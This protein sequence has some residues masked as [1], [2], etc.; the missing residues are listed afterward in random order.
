MGQS[1]PLFVYFRSFLITISIQ[2]EKSI[3]GVLGIQT[4]GRKMVGADETTE[5]W[6]P[7]TLCICW[8]NNIFI[9]L[10]KSKPTGGQLNIWYHPMVSVLRPNQQK[11]VEQF[12][13]IPSKWQQRS[14]GV[15]RFTS[16]AVFVETLAQEKAVNC[17]F[18]LLFPYVKEK[19]ALFIFL[20]YKLC[21]INKSTIPFRSVPTQWKK[22]IKKHYFLLFFS[23]LLHNQR[24]HI[25]DV[26]E[27]QRRKVSES[28]Q[29][30]SK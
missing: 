3:D 20:I 13:W 4:Q 28:P 19:T 30:W 6:R 5:L 14:Q 12:L 16:K 8:M 24:K 7:P 9:Y 11:R 2:I 15:E 26:E 18:Q 29:N 25:L 27:M 21:C 22:Q 10:V 17:F 23:S 1:R